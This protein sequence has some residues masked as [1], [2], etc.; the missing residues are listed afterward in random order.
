MPPPHCLLRRPAARQH[1]SAF[2]IVWT[3]LLPELSSFF[4]LC[5]SF[6]FALSL[7][8]S[9]HLYS[10]TPREA[11]PHFVEWIRVCV[12]LIWGRNCLHSSFSYF[13]CT[14]IDCFCPYANVWH[15]ASVC[16][17][18]LERTHTRT[19]I[20]QKHY[21]AHTS[22]SVVQSA[23]VLIDLLTVICVLSFCWHEVI[24]CIALRAEKVDLFC[25]YGI[26]ILSL[27]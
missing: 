6:C 7:S 20:T 17:E 12:H 3:T 21:R 1:V 26:S 23:V 14:I 11:T 19:H 5:L 10:W 4:S 22:G 8:V 2:G 13:I 15:I 9:F 18:S 27:L 25:H 24:I 16:F